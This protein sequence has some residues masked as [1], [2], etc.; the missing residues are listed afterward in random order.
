MY[1]YR[2]NEEKSEWIIYVTDV[3][4]QQH[5]DMVFSVCIQIHLLCS[6]SVLSLL[7]FLTHYFGDFLYFFF[8]VHTRLWLVE[9]RIFKTIVACVFYKLY[10][11]VNVSFQ[12][13]SEHQHFLIYRLPNVLV[14]FRLMIAHT[15]RL[16]MLGLAL[17]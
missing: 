9:F 2:L 13:E 3:G 6:V 17:F 10:D 11:F 7:L 12:L 14:G 15:L 8:Y 4:Q 1:R 5:F 16:A